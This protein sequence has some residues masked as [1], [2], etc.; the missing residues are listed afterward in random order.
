MTTYRLDTLAASH[1]LTDG[2]ERAKYAVEAAQVLRRSLAA[3]AP[4]VQRPEDAVCVIHINYVFVGSEHEPYICAQC[5]VVCQHV[6]GQNRN[7]RY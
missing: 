6:F 2:E 3:I 1:D 4:V 5:D 7:I